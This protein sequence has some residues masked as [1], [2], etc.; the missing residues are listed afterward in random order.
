GMGVGYYHFAR[1]DLS[2]KPEDEATWFHQTAS[3]EAGEILALDFEVSY[4]GDIVA[5]CKTFLDSLSSKLNGY[6]PLIYL[7]QSLL[8]S[9]DWSSVFNAGYGLWLADYDNSVT[10]VA[11][12]WPNDEAFKQFTDSAV[13]GGVI[14]KVDEDVL[15]GDINTFKAYGYQPSYTPT[16]PTVGN[17]PIG[18]DVPISGDKVKILL[19]VPYG[20]QEIQA[21]NSMLK[22]KDNQITSLTNQVSLLTR[23]D[24]TGSTTPMPQPVPV[25]PQPTPQPT[26]TP[27]GNFLTNLWHSLFG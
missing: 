2:N 21:I 16:P 3:P 6:K 14:G 24:Q 4:G 17:P 27:S 9:H 18:P 23:S 26:P 13:V 20:V 19:A 5:W 25:Q 10:D 8:R 22:D 15:F 11:T 12:P 7:N 1:P